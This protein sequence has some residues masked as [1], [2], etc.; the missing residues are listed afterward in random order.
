MDDESK[1]GA[2]TERDSFGV[3]MVCD[4]PVGHASETAP[5]EYHHAFLIGNRKITEWLWADGGEP[6]R[7]DMF[8]EGD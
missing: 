4:K 8:N 2:E 7:I 6:F 3:F 1:C 5:N